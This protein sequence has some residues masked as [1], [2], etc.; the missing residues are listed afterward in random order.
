MANRRK[1]RTRVG[2]VWRRNFELVL[3]LVT[4]S[5]FMLQSDKFDEI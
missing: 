4:V 5:S 2:G 3:L 1:A